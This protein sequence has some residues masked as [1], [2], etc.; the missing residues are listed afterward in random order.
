MKGGCF[1]MGD[2]YADPAADEDYPGNERPVHEA[3]VGDYYLGK[4]EVTRGQWK[5]LMR[6]EPKGLATCAS[7]RCPVQGMSWEE[8]QAFLRA[9]NAKEKAGTYRLP[10]EAEWEYAARSGGKAERYAGGNDL[11]AVAWYDATVQALPRAL[12]DPMF[13][14]VGQRA[15]NGLGLYDMSGNVYELT[16]DWFEPGYYAKGPPRM[17]PTGPASGTARVK[18]GGCASGGPN[19]QRVSRRMD[20]EVEGN[21]STGFRVVW[22]P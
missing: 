19:N 10:T 6:K 11:D 9:L 7:D 8:V 3:C 12:T 21:G 4:Y 15:P 20:W 14:P 2:L 1:Q 13:Q 18:R 17:N 5:A 16:S 22:T